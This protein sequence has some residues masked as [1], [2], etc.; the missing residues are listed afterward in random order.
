MG[1]HVVE[2]TDAN[3]DSQ[4]VNNNGVVL[5]D[6]WAAWCMPCRAVA[7]VVEELAAEYAGKAMVAKLNVD[8]NPK[9]AAAYGIMS[10]PTLMIFKNGQVVDQIVGAQPKAVLAKRLD[11]ALK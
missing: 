6:F 11:E 8:E 1:Q 5:V 9:T 2:L 4:V 7:P 10:I 3:F